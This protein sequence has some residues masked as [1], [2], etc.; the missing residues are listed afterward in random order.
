MLEHE[1]EVGPLLFPRHDQFGTSV[2]ERLHDLGR[3]RP[4]SA[5]HFAHP[6]FVENSELA[7]DDQES[8]TG[9]N[10]RARPSFLESALATRV[11]SAATTK[12][13]SIVSLGIVRFLRSLALQRPYQALRAFVAFERSLSV[14]SRR[15]GRPRIRT[16]AQ[17]FRGS[18]TRF[19]TSLAR[20][21]GN[22]ADV[23]SRPGSAGAKTAP[24]S[25]H[26]FDVPVALCLTMP[27]NWT[28][29]VPPI[30]RSP[31]RARALLALTPRPTRHR[32]RRPSFFV[33]L[34]STSIGERTGDPD[35]RL[36]PL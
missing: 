17:S 19:K 7:P 12:T 5:R 24:V 14:L 2:V 21:P 36:L 16:G 1:D 34:C 10:T 29:D 33:K 3:L 8:L 25:A 35:S 20:A 18:G 23:H 31:P 11:V 28:R 6:A 22:R 30:R 4:R 15:R 26:R 9:T 27:S 32:A 13:V